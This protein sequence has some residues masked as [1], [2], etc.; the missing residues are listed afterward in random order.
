M[1]VMHP[2]L[3]ICVYFPIL[4][5]LRSHSYGGK[6]CRISLGLRGAAHLLCHLHPWSMFLPSDMRGWGQS[7]RDKEEVGMS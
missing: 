2:R 6:A 5:S 1:A 4:I 3:S 7:N